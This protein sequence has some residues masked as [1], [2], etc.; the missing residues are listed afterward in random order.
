[1][2]T[3]IREL[4]DADLDSVSGGVRGYTYCAVGTRQGGGPGLYPE[5]AKDDCLVYTVAEVV[6]SFYKAAT[7]KSLPT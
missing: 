4:N 2:N 1:M 3:E 7:G 5:G 6:G